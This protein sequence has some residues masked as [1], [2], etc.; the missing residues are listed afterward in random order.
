MPAFRSSST[1][2]NRTPCTDAARAA[3]CA[4]P[5]AGLSGVGRLVR[6]DRELRGS[7]VLRELFLPVPALNGTF[8]LPSRFCLTGIR[9]RNGPSTRL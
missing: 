5:E 3:I 2:A 4:G 7:P 8:P 6:M 1:T 9:H